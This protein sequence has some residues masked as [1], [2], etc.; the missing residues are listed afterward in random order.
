[1]RRP[2]SVPRPRRTKASFTLVSTPSAI[3]R[4]AVTRARKAYAAADVARPDGDSGS[5][6]A[7]PD[8]TPKVGRAPW[9]HSL[10]R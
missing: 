5:P 1:M 7:G 4:V 6:E 9:K 2:S 10:G 8:I 3:G